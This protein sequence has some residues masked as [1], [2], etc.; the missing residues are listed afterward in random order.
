MSYSHLDEKGVVPLNTFLRNTFRLTGTSNLNDKLTATGSVAYTNSQGRRIQ[1]G[2]NLSGLMLGLLRASP[3]FDNSNGATDVTDPS[4]FLLAD[5]SQRNYRGGGGYDNPYWTINQNPFT[6]QVNRVFGYGKLDYKFNDWITATARVGS[7]YYSD[8][9]NQIFAINSRSFP[10]G[11]VQEDL[12]NT[13]ETTADLFLSFNK[14]LNES[15]R[16]NGIVGQNYNHRSFKNDYLTGDAL[17][18]S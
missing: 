9:R 7:D 11:R 4:S 15:I 1:Q 16:I 3:T 10:A 17:N 6:D 2:S 5:G 12:Y 14:S 13:S 18:F 8:V